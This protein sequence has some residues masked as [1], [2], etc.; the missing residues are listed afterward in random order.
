M[1]TDQPAMTASEAMITL[2]GVIRPLRALLD[3]ENLLVSAVALER[4]AH[5]HSAEIASRRASLDALDRELSAMAGAVDAARS[6]AA[7]L[8]A[9][10]HAKANDTEAA[11]QRNVDALLKDAEAIKAGARDEAKVAKAKR[12]ASEA[13]ER[14]AQGNL[15]AIAKRIGDLA[16]QL[17]DAQAIIAKA[18]R[19]K[20]ASE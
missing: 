2:Q 8:I 13:A 6:E 12:D 5:D 18:E 20:K 1:P 17:A 15:D 7:S 19:I 14:K 11:A 10:A 3:I 4:E 9:N 16:V